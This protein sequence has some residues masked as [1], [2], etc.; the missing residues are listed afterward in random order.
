[1]FRKPIGLRRGTGYRHT[2][3]GRANG[4]T[5]TAGAEP[6][7]NPTWAESGMLAGVKRADSGPVAWLTPSLAFA[8]VATL[9]GLGARALGVPGGVAP[10]L[11]V[12]ISGLIVGSTLLAVGMRS[13][14]D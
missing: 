9:V 1:M 13:S 2:A 3:R 11:G 8:V 14:K 5:S 4:I 6:K 10:L 7:S 12:L